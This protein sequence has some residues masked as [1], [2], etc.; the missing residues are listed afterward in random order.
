MNENHN[1]LLGH[2][3]ILWKDQDYAFFRKCGEITVSPDQQCFG[4]NCRF[5]AGVCLQFEVF[6][7]HI[8]NQHSNQIEE[9]YLG[10]AEVQSIQTQTMESR[11]EEPTSPSSGNSLSFSPQWSLDNELNADE[12]DI[13]QQV[14]EEIVNWLETS[15]SMDLSM[16]SVI[17]STSG[18]SSANSSNIVSTTFSCQDLVKNEETSLQKQQQQKFLMPEIEPQEEVAAVYIM[19]GDLANDL[20]MAM[21]EGEEVPFDFKMGDNTNNNENSD[22]DNSIDSGIVD[23]VSTRDYKL[24]HIGINM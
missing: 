16:D 1:K 8:K 11:T 9:L 12:H 3:N 20:V 23:K 18:C 13:S 15:S 6:Q 19:E 5:C 7:Q 10:A 14:A 2:T 22:A 21:E 4:F 24:L 17:T